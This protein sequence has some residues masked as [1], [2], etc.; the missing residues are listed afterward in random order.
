MAKLAPARRVALKLLSEQRRR[1][2]RIHDIA[3]NSD[4]FNMLDERDR[5]F[6]MTLVVG[7]NTTCGLLDLQLNAYF[8]KPNKVE[9]RV[10]D[11]LRIATFEILY[12]KLSETAVDQGVEL[13]KSVQPYAAGMAN[14]VL[15]RMLKKQA[16]ME[17]CEV[18]VRELSSQEQLAFDD[19]EELDL[20]ALEAVS[21]YP[22]WLTQCLVEN[23]E[24]Y[25]A[26]RMMLD[27]LSAAPSSQA[28]IGDN[29][30]PCDVSAQ[31]VAALAAVPGGRVLEVGQGR[32]TK[33]LIM[34]SLGA[35]VAGCELHQFK[36]AETER[37]ASFY[38]LSN[39]ISATALD[40]LKLG[41]DSLPDALSGVFDSVL[42]DA[43]CS[44]TGTMRRHPEIPWHLVQDSVDPGSTE[45]LP[46]LQ[47]KLLKAASKRVA[48]S[49]Q[50]IYSTC[51]VLKAE[52]DWVINAF[53]SSEEGVDFKRM[54]LLAASGLDN[55]NESQAAHLENW[56]TP[57]GAFQSYPGA[58]LPDGHFCCYLRRA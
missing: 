4:A 54:S 43:P 2:A 6:C 10:R 53:L 9:P 36:C 26:A 21:G 16:M 1:G 52:N 18:R 33:S 42:V 25:L 29:L 58:G 48:G 11:A 15:R 37:R 14:A 57:T 38:G 8:E 44:G 3:R 55:L 46:A 56:L 7:V 39:Q 41:E 5:N 34:A 28:R 45:S 40:G 22:A 50:L 27:S 51:S 17:A 24:P 12:H 30:I 20:R 47:L 31:C 35:R 13:V 49:G 23:M 19:L 32:G